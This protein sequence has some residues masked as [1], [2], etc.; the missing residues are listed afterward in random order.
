LK[1]VFYLSDILVLDAKIYD[2]EDERK[3]GERVKG[4]K[5]FYIDR[6]MMGDNKFEFGYSVCE[7]FLKDIE[8]CI[9]QVPGYYAAEYGSYM[10]GG[11]RIMKLT[12]INFIGDVSLWNQL[13]EKS[14]KVS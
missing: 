13:Q 4:V 9:V 2:F 10:K 14:S 1:E 7:A 5:L 12:D 8:D 3:K 6:A 11:Q